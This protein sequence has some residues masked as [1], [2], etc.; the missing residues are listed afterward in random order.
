M[1]DASIFSPEAN[2]KL[3]ANFATRASP[4]FIG[5]SILKAAASLACAAG[6][7]QPF[8]QSCLQLEM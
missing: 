7:A 4:G 8:E 6:K 1:N 2:P 5:T 3:R